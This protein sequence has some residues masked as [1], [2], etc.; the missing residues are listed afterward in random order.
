MVEDDDIA[1]VMLHNARIFPSPP[2][3]YL[4]Y[5]YHFFFLTKS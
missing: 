4:V 5:V 1:G 2:T 3:H